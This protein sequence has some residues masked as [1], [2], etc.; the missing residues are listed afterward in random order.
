MFRRK[1]FT[2]ATVFIFILFYYL[3]K[4]KH[5]NKLF[6][7]HNIFTEF[8]AFKHTGASVGDTWIEN[9]VFFEAPL[10]HLKG[11]IAF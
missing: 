7:N 8:G 3:K 10:N 11:L 4:K 1:T 6:Q 5:S 2:N 9:E